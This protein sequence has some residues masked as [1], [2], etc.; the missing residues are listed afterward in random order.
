[1]SRR[2]AI[3]LE[4]RRARRYVARMERALATAE[5]RALKLAGGNARSAYVSGLSRGRSKAM[6]APVAKL[7]RPWRQLLHPA[8]KIGGVLRRRQLW[9]IIPTGSHGVEVDI[10]PR[11]Q[12]LLARWQFGDQS[13]PQELR[14][15]LSDI[16]STP[17]GR[18]RYYAHIAPRR[19]SWP[20]DPLA[21][22]PV[23]EQP[24]REVVSHV[25]SW[26]RANIGA[27]YLSI[28]AKLTSG[29]IKPPRLRAAT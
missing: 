2:P 13:R 22:P 19:P 8:T 17:A 5:S 23:P 29:A 3:S 20:R 4:T 18:R 10:A 26:A 25:R 7:D 6:P 21:L 14:S 28:L 24:R 16:Q 1:M 9:R 27:W 12:D 11:L 15:W